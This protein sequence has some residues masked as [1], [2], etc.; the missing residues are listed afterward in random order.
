[1]MKQ[2]VEAKGRRPG[3]TRNRSAVVDDI[4]EP[5]S[6]RVPDVSRGFGPKVRI[7]CFPNFSHRPCQDSVIRENIQS[8]RLICMLATA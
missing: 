7:N 8:K 6:R 2:K 1:M 4:T 5:L 3:W